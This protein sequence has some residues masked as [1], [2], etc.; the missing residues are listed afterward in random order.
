MSNVF[1]ITR[2]NNTNSL[3]KT[4]QLSSASEEYIEILVESISWFCHP[5]GFFGTSVC[6]GG[7]QSGHKDCVKVWEFTKKYGGHQGN[8]SRYVVLCPIHQYDIHVPNIWAKVSGW[9]S[10]C[11][12]NIIFHAVAASLIITLA[13]I[14]QKWR[15]DQGSY[16]FWSVPR[17]P[18]I[19]G[20]AEKTVLC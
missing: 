14:E 19:R 6:A 18:A 12:V 1:S 20:F 3:K 9:E 13:Q 16:H 11:N 8:K 7:G 15:W 17:Y 5:V 10:S 2:G 4:K